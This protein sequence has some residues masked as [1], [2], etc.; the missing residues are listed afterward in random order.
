M[1][2]D[3]NDE[4]IIGTFYEQELQGLVE[5]DLSNYATKSATATASVEKSNKC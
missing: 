5:V 1:I 3:V 2:K 4:E